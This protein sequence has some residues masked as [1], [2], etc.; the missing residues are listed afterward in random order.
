MRAGPLCSVLKLRTR[1]FTSSRC[2]RIAAATQSGA[3]HTVPI[4]A[5]VYRMVDTVSG[6]RQ[7]ATT[8]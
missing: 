8:G 1:R 5:V 4:T 6:H 3:L 7:R 2:E